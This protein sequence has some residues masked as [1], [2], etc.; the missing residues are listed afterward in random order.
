MKT[1]EVKGEYTTRPSNNP[2]GRPVEL[3]GGQYVKFYADAET[4]AR[5]KAIV[6]AKKAKNKSEAIRNAVK[7]FHP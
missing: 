2:E 1:D 3:K 7:K 4:I 5:I 6:K